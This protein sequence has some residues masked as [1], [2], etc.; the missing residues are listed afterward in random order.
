M[1]IIPA[2]I[3]WQQQIDQ[4]NQMLE[5]LIKPLMLAPESPIYESIWALQVALTKAVATNVADEVDWLEWY[6]ADNDMGRLALKASPVDG[7][8]TRKI[9]SIADLAWLIQESK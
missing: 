8:P 7:K 6:W 3:D 9:Q 5:T 1:N 4:S 2:L